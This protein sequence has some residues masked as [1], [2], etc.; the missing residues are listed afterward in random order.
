MPDVVTIVSL[1][2]G[3]PELIT[4]KGLN[5]LQ[6]ADSIFCPATILPDGT[7]ISR[8]KDIL[9]EL[10]IDEAKI[11]LFG[12][13]MSENRI[14]AIKD[15]CD[16]AVQIEE[17][18]H[19][20]CHVALVVEGDAGFYSSS[21]YISEILVAKGI[22]VK[23]IAGIPAFIACAASNNICISKQKEDTLIVTDLSS[24]EELYEKV[25]KG[26]TVVVMKASKFEGI[27]KEFLLV[28][29]EEIRFHYFENSG[30]SGKEFYT[31][32]T[33]EICTRR[34][35]YFSLLIIQ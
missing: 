21:H 20:G 8:S 25:G 9:A 33:S 15:Y 1:G 7:K 14:H 6:W 35:P 17:K 18:Y 24:M 16:V 2:P 10:N 30:I 11:I 27:I 13:S 12:V 28:A 34:F 19:S 3:D 22:P 5:V 31:D 32:R 26:R 4:L 29:G 23:R